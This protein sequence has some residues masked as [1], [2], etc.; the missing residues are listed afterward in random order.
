MWRHFK[1]SAPSLRFHVNG[2]ISRYRRIPD[3]HRPSTKR[4]APTNCAGKA[5]DGDVIV[6]EYFFPSITVNE[7]IKI[8]R[9]S[10]K[11][12]TFQFMAPNECRDTDIGDAT[13]NRDIR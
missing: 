13:G 3:H 2:G 8:W 4:I 11:K 7:D 6:A 1:N 12:N 5:V 9:G 10:S